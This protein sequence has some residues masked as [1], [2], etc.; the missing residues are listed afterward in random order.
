MSF[1]RFHHYSKRLTVGAI[2]RDFSYVKLI[3]LWCKIIMPRISWEWAY[4]FQNLKAQIQPSKGTKETLSILGLPL[5]QQ[6]PKNH[7]K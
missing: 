2:K 6:T 3:Q 1:V 7:V 5:T 4:R